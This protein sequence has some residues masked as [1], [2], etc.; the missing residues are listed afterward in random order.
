LKV[1]IKLFLRQLQKVAENYAQKL[2]KASFAALLPLDIL[3]FY[4]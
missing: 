3:P 4:A 1:N 2:Q